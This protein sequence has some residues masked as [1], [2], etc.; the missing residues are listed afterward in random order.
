MFQQFILERESMKLTERHVEISDDEAGNF[1]ARS[2]E[3]K[4]QRTIFS[5]SPR[6]INIAQKG[7]E[8]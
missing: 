7:R 6:I 4:I 8:E 1:N 2:I 5:L 3:L